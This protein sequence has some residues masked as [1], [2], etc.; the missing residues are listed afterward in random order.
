VAREHRRQAVN[1]VSVGNAITSMRL[2]SM[3]DW[4]VFFER[5]QSRRGA[6]A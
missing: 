3:I 5:F 6:A 2:L 1:Q 4:N